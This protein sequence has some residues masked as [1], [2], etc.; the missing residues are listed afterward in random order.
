M[1]GW[2][3]PALVLGA[4]LAAAQ[5]SVAVAQVADL[6]RGTC[7]D[8]VALSAQERSQVALWLHGFYSGAALRAQIDRSR[9]PDLE[10]SLVE[11]CEKQPS[12][13]LI[14]AELRGVVLIGRE[15]APPPPGA[16]PAPPPGANAPASPPPPDRPTPVR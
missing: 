13:P 15:A 2:K 7:A 9:L 16:Q 12:L 11:V 4:W 14:G 10:P 3:R 5:P 8:F 1:T 6:S